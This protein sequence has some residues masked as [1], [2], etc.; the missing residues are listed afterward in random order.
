MLGCFD[1]GTFMRGCGLGFLRIKTSH[2]VLWYKIESLRSDHENYDTLQITCCFCSLCYLC[3]SRLSANQPCCLNALGSPYAFYHDLC[4]YWSDRL[5]TCAIAV[6]GITEPLQILPP[7]LLHTT[8]LAACPS[9]A[10]RCILPG[11]SYLIR[12]LDGST[13]S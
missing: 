10:F 12:L 9:R 8:L 7:P 3:A 2:H 6:S 1:W 11:S 13:A 5:E 4:L